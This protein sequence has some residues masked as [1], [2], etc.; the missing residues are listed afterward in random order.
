MQTLTR[1]AT[2]GTLS[3]IAGEGGPGAQ[4]RVGEGGTQNMHFERR[5]H[6]PS[7]DRRVGPGWTTSGGEVRERETLVHKRFE[8]RLARLALVPIDEDQRPLLPALGLAFH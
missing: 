3:R 8:R 7:S 6:E 2:L 1:L 5:D 4:R